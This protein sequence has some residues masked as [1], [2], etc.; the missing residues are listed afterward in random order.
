MRLLGSSTNIIDAEKNGKLVPK[1]E[2]VDFVLVHCNLVK[3][4]YQKGSRVLLTFAPN[5]TYGQL[6]TTIPHPLIML[7]TVST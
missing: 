4:T 5:K 3:N 7:K 6:M 2:S 1:L